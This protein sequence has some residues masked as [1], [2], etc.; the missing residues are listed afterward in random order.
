MPA[1][2]PSTRTRRRDDRRSQQA[3]SYRHLYGTARWRK[4]REWQLDR[5]PLCA[6]CHE[7]GRITAANTAD[8][9]VAHKGD[10]AL[11]WGG[12]LR[13]LCASCHS[14]VKQ[15]EERGHHRP[16]IGLDGWPV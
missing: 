8:H 6:M 9:V 13:S 14:S 2:R 15:A 16:L 3:A 5:E 7:M 11:F 1:S 12:E 10:E 4:L